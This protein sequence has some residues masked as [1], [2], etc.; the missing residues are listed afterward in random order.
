M[1]GEGTGLQHS[2]PEAC[3]GREE[4]SARPSRHHA[5]ALDGHARP[6]L[7]ATAAHF[8]FAA[9]LAQEPP[10]MPPRASAGDIPALV[11]QLRSS[12]RVAQAQAVTAV[13]NLVGDSIE[14]RPGYCCS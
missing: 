9:S 6:R 4:L 12:R 13:L 14:N 2:A 5:S 10:T 1:L 3:R 11:Q 7:P 8:P